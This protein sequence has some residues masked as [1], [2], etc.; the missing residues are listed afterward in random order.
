ME[1]VNLGVR[2]MT[3]ANCT[4]RVER[5]LNKLDGVSAGCVNRAT[6]RASVQFNPEQT[7][8]PALLQA[9]EKAGYTPIT[10]QASLSVGGM[11]CANCVSRVERGLKKLDGVLDA[12]V[13]LAT[14]RATVTFL[15]G[16]TTGAALAT[17]V[18]KAGY[19]VREAPGSSERV[20]VERQAREE[21]TR[22]LK[23][24]VLI[25]AVFTLPLLVFVML[26][27]LIPSFEAW[28]MQR[29][30]MQTINVVSF[31][32]A[33][34]VQFGPGR[35]FYRPDWNGLRHGS[36]DMNSL[37]MSGTTAALGFLAVATVC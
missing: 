7:D 14:E 15:P 26:P 1:S 9:V 8:V 30:S 35:R 17:A 4:G 22:A 28:L 23:R 24:D 37:V 5:A 27:M 21:E 25:S 13:N 3:C 31:F 33:S 29:V 2:G 6:E 10:E 19:E 18:T 36:P 32:L 12:N 34:V 20:D 16:L 11:T